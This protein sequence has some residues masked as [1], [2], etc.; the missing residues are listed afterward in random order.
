MDFTPEYIRTSRML[1][2]AGLIT[3][4]VALILITSSALGSRAGRDP[5]APFAALFSLLT[6]TLLLAATIL[7]ALWY[8][9]VR[10]VQ[11]GTPRFSS[12]YFMEVSAAALFLFAGAMMLFESFQA[13]APRV[14]VG[15]VATRIPGPPK[16]PPSLG[17]VLAILGSLVL[18]GALGSGQWLQGGDGAGYGLWIVCT[19]RGC[20]QPPTAPDYME[21]PRALLLLSLGLGLVSVALSARGLSQ[22][23][24]LLPS[25]AALAAGLSAMVATAVFAH[26][27]A[28]TEPFTRGHVGFGPGF[29][30]GWAVGPLFLLAAGA[31]NLL[32]QCPACTCAGGALDP[33]RSSRCPGPGRGSRMVL[34]HALHFYPPGLLDVSRGLMLVSLLAAFIPVLCLLG[35][36]ARFFGRFFAVSMASYITSLV[37]GVVSL[38]AMG[39]FALWASRTPPHPLVARAYGWAFYLGW[40]S[41][42]TCLLSGMTGLIAH[43]SLSAST[44]I[45]APPPA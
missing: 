30:L 3:G 14:R 28:G 2:V 31:A 24:A 29:R 44:I 37:A 8:L 38:L 9:P 23:Q 40:A 12:P 4:I 1:T 34:L 19:P 17:Q 26:G 5:V 41:C 42:P 10:S 21:V 16:V 13:E 18:L 32:S 22:P 43:R 27:A 36:V 15:A 39:S 20:A 33:S 35:P 7:F 6:G 25:T 45:L 11:M